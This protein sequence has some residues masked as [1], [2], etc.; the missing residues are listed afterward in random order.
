[1]NYQGSAML[2]RQISPPN[3]MLKLAEQIREALTMFAR[4]VTESTYIGDLAVAA[5]Q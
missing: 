4:N 2:Q 5:H 1:M 3:P